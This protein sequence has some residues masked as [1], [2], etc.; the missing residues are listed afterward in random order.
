MAIK[1]S[2]LIC[3]IP[4]RESLLFKL[5]SKLM[6]QITPEIQVCISTDNKTVSVGVKRQNLLCS[7][8]GDY[9][10]F[11]DDDDDI[12]DYYI[13]EILK[14][15]EAGPDCVGFKIHCDM[16]GKTQM[17]VGSLKYKEWADNF[18]GFDY[19]RSPYHKNPVKRELALQTG[20]LD[21]RYAEDHDYSKRLL[22]LLSSEVFID[23]I[24]Y[25]Y[26]YR[27]EPHNDKYGIDAS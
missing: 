7:A 26:K 27:P 1:L 19:V 22:P 10:C 8:I 25:H 9:I 2:I 20:F 23:K 11:I 21:M 6:T 13:E 24:M 3:S 12:P 5:Y 4:K 18:D 14:A 16:N 15:L 17:A